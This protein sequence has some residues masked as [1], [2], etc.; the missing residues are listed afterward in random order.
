MSSLLLLIFVFITWCLCAVAAAA[1]R[2]V[3][4]AHREAPTPGVS[5]FPVIPVVPLALWLLS[6]LFKP[7]GTRIVAGLHLV[8]LIVLVISIARD[9][10]RLRSAKNTRQTHD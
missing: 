9:F 3:E 2:A 1:H 8:L 4:A 6:F 7:W 5:I 10:V